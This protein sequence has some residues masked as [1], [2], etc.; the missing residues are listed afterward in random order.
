MR[1]FSKCR[2]DVAKDHS[3]D[4]DGELACSCLMLLNRAEVLDW[5][6]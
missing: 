1:L 5:Y 6:Y 4:S 2:A 3:E